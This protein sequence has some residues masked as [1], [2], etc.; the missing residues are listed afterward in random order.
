MIGQD[1]EPFC[2]SALTISLGMSWL[3]DYN[4]QEVVYLQDVLQPTGSVKTS[5]W[6]GTQSLANQTARIL[7][8][9][10]CALLIAEGFDPK[11]S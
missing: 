10:L 6:Y 9:C 5:A 8:L 7:G 3:T 11:E 2:C 4:A 1:E